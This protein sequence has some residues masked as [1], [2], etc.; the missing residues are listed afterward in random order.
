MQR[1]LPLNVVLTQI[2]IRDGFGLDLKLNSHENECVVY[3][4]PEVM[5]NLIEFWKAIVEEK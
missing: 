5:Q 3:F 1:R 2:R 4:E